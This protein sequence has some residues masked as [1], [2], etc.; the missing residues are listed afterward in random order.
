[1]QPMND[2]VLGPEAQAILR[3]ALQAHET[4]RV[5]RLIGDTSHCLDTDRIRRMSAVAAAA[6]VHEQR[7]VIACD[8]CNSRVRAFQKAK[9]TTPQ[10]MCEKRVKDAKA[11]QLFDALRREPAWQVSD[12]VA[13]ELRNAHR[14]GASDSDT[15]H[16]V[17]TLLDPVAAV[18]HDVL[19]RWSIDFD[20]AWPMFELLRETAKEAARAGNATR[21]QFVSSYARIA[22]G[23]PTHLK[24]VLVDGI[25]HL[26]GD[27]QLAAA[28]STEIEMV[29]VSDET[30][31]FLASRH[32]S[33]QFEPDEVADLVAATLYSLFEGLLSVS[34]DPFELLSRLRTVRRYLADLVSITRELSIEHR[35]SML[36][37]AAKPL[38]AYANDDR[39]SV[40]VAMEASHAL[41]G[42]SLAYANVLSAMLATGR[43]ELLHG[44]VVGLR[45]AFDGT[46]AP[47]YERHGTVWHF[48]GPPSH[49]LHETAAEVARLVEQH[50]ELVDAIE[51]FNHRFEPT[52]QSAL[53]RVK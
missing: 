6:T 50:P 47:H 17:A 31:T 41:A 3:K 28:L 46:A 44:V 10:Q 29:D 15:A 36:H 22:T 32:M 33:A 13:D 38:L 24:A 52:A 14:R 51:W 9:E 27:D 19:S 43:P 23:A 42:A 53:E 11:R 16:L 8:W 5:Q 45:K 48:A 37:A 1:M 34:D 40:F 49:P 4:E 39:A 20:S 21:D 30:Q 26:A 35:D 25:D 2:D 12:A 18:S 7:H